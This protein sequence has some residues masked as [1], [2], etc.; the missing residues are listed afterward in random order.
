M[1]MLID[2]P[3]GA[4][5]DAH[6]GSFTV[7]TDQPPAASAP[8]PFATFLA[9]LG[10][11]AG[12][13]VLGFCQQRGL[14]TEGIRIVQRMHSNPMSGM[15]EKIDLEIQVPPSFPEKYRSSLI[16][17]AELC[18]VKKHLENPPSFEVTTKE[19]AVA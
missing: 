1:E 4:R 17:S 10:T 19:V 8:T 13:Y 2:F 14:P 11:C 5:V 9:S 7:H 6:F 18:A 15:V 16:R 3:G 12:I